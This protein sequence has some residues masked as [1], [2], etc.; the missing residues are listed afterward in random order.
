[1][2]K[3]G[4]P[5]LHPKVVLYLIVGAALVALALVGSR[6]GQAQ[7]GPTLLPAGVSAEAR[8]SAGSLNLRTG[9]HVSYTAVAYLMEGEEVRL[10]GR[11]RTGTWVQIELY[12]GYRGWVNASYIRPTVDI[13]A[14]PIADVALWGITAFVTND[15]VPVYAGA[16]TGYAL[17]GRAQPGEVLSLNG[18]N[19][20]AT[21]VHV[22]L[23]DGRAG[24]AAADS[25]FLPSAAINDLPIL[26]PFLDAPPPDLAPFFLVYTGPGF[27]YEPIDSVAE[28]QTLG[29]IARTADSRWVLVRL[30]NGREG[31]IAAEIVHVG[32]ALAN[33]PVT[34]GIAPPQVVGWQAS[35]RQASDSD[36]TGD[37]GGSAGGKQ[38]S[39]PSALTTSTPDAFPT[40]PPATATP[41]ATVTSQVTATTPATTPT[42]GATLP[43]AV[44]ATATATTR[45]TETP[46]ATATA[47]TEPSDNLTPP[48]GLP[49][50]YVYATPDDTTEP[51]L[52]VVPGQSV[53]LIGRTADAQWVKIWL[54]GGQEG[55][56]RADALQLEI[57]VT[58]LPVVEP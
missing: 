17:V 18:R 44:T 29:I 56:I 48:P 20:A 24:W 4:I 26:T 34:A 30:A 31:W 37:D 40:P 8:V 3:L 36:Q 12:N 53:V 19:D 52:R 22:Y 42:V 45:P 2:R 51:I 11:N 32:A 27:L 28:G 15:P 54:P 50:V 9:P 55:W 7:T 57:D 58:V 25:S 41:E 1:M 33:V 49:I 38:P 21:W 10:I 35:G 13:A 5:R 6:R 47:T 43:P 46:E 16:D 23:P 39:I 14:L